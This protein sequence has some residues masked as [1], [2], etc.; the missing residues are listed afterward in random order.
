MLL[1]IGALTNRMIAVLWIIAVLANL[2]AVQRVVYTL[3]ELR[4]R[5]R[6]SDPR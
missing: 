3:R 4:R 2:T 1:I 6:T 5:G